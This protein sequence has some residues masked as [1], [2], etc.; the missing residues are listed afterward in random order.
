MDNSDFG[1]WCRRIGVGNEYQN[2]INK[3]DWPVASGCLLVG[4]Q[5]TGDLGQAAIS[6]RVQHHL[7]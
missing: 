5:N 7:I 6:Q 4:L 3:F 1:A 2:S